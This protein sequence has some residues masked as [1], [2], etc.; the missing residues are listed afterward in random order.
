MLTIK[1]EGDFGKSMI[2]GLKKQLPYVIAKALTATAK[3][4]QR[5]IPAALEQQLDRPT[6]FTKSGVFVI[7]ARKDKLEAVVGFK[8]KQARYMRLQI[9]GGTRSPGA[10]GLK[11]PGDVVL[12]EF[13]NIPRGTIAKMIQ[14]AKAGKYGKAVKTRLGINARGKA[15]AN[16]SLF[17]GQPKGHPDLPAGI[18]RR[19]GHKIV[20]VIVFPTNKSA[21]YK[22]RFKFRELAKRTVREVWASEFDKAFADAMRTAR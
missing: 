21:R 13:G 1:V 18:W 11:L 9:E 17:Y 3:E 15:P 7:P 22:P 12:N 10:R 6:P 8:D 4:L 19:E 5:R 16:L 2:A 14:A 20:P